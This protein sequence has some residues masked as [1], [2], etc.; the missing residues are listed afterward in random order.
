MAL[1]PKRRELVGLV[2]ATGALVAVA[3]FVGGFMSPRTTIVA[4]FGVW[5]VGTTLV[6]VITDPPKR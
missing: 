2:G 6:Y 3:G 1:K 5:A 4:C